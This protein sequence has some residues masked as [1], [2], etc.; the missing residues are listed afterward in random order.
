MNPTD[1]LRE[2][3][4]AFNDEVLFISPEEVDI[5]AVWWLDKTCKIAEDAYNKGYEDAKNKLL[6][7]PPKIV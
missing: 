6:G 5:V 1:K 4:R 7:I 3:W 2:E